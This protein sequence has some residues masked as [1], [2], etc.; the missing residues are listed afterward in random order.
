MII[1]GAISQQHVEA[2]IRCPPKR[3]AVVNSTGGDVTQARALADVISGRGVNTLAV[4]EVAS[5]ALIVWAA[6]RRRL[7]LPSTV[8]LW[9]EPY[10][11]D[12]SCPASSADLLV[13]AHSLD[14]WFAW[15]CGLLARHSNEEAEFWARVGA[16][17]GSELSADQLLDAGLASYVVEKDLGQLLDAALKDE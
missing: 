16:G 14:A 15:A 9:H 11:E 3:L 4:G 6:G 7:I 8:A 10:A 12:V 17:A 2:I 5:S 13:L 1:D